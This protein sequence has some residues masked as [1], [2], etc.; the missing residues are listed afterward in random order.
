MNYLTDFSYKP[1]EECA[2]KIYLLKIKNQ[3][4]RIKDV[5]RLAQDHIPG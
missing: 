4:V 1:Y 5:K 3:K 2:I